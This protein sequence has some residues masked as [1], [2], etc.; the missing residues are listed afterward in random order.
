MSRFKAVWVPVGAFGLAVALALLAGPNPR[1]FG[2]RLPRAETPGKCVC[3]LKVLDIKCKADW[4]L[5][6]IG[7]D[8]TPAINQIKVKIDAKI[9]QERPSGAPA[10]DILTDAFVHLKVGAFLKCNGKLDG[11]EKNLQVFVKPQ[12]KDVQTCPGQNYEYT[13]EGDQDSLHLA[14]F[15]K[16]QQ[17]LKIQRKDCEVLDV[18]LFLEG[19]GHDLEYHVSTE[20]HC[21]GELLVNSCMD[22][23]ELRKKKGVLEGS[24][25]HSKNCS[26]YVCRFGNP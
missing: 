1:A 24:S 20:T 22:K 16:F 17:L 9:C 14:A 11:D 26:I 3:Q 5:F 2:I 4:K 6:E 19:P 23:V 18:L 12:K 25:S 21:G 7:E 13:W 10:N 15:E 8:K